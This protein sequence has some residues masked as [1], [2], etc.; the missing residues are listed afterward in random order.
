MKKICYVVTIPLT[1]RAFFIPQLHFLADN[2]YEVTVIC[3]KDD[4]LQSELG[5]KVKFIPVNIPRGINP[6]GMIKA[7]TVLRKIF[8]REKFD[9]VQY[10]T[11]NAS[12]CAA[13]AASIS[14]IECRNYHLM[15]FRY[16]GANGIM[17]S[18]LKTLEKITCSYS[19]TIEC[20]SKSNLKLGIEEK[21]FSADK[22][23]VVWNG[24]TGGV[25]LKRFD[26]SNKELW[27]KQIRCELQLD[28]NDLLFAYVGRITRDKGIDELLEAFFS[29]DVEAKLLIIGSDEGVD[30]LNKTLWDKAVNSE[31]VI[32][33]HQVD[34]V[35][36]YY[37]CSDVLVLPSY[38]EGFGN[39]IIEA[40][41]MG[42]PAIVSDIP[43]PIDAVVEGKTGYICQCKDFK[44]ILEAMNRI[45]KNN[46]YL[47]MSQ[48]A[49]DFALK[50]FD[51]K[52]LCEKI[53][54][55]KINLLGE[56]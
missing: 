38:R 4:E 55:R 27:R 37:A 40:A 49:Y 11:P 7:I 51:S 13:I 48:N 53:L 10:S 12:L 36:K 42:V 30:T 25:D 24:S 6:L 18:V 1:I 44:S 34:D 54:E 43:G 50:N 14:N 8:S 26:I 21:V 2:G 28:E 22:A 47:L 3:S 56:N 19:T 29:L 35:E 5:D 46:D 41:A 17:R 16:L 45:I 9:I 33:H 15:G 39:V 52:V 20:V 31:N 32:I 23:S